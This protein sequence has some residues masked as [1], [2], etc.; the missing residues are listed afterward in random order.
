LAL[1][2]ASGQLVIATFLIL[3]IQFERGFSFFSPKS[4]S[5]EQKG[6]KKIYLI[7]LHLKQGAMLPAAS[8]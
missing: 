2:F 5:C 7:Q 1:V 6:K 3:C 4:A 8:V